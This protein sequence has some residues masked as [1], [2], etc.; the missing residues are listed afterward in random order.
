MAYDWICPKFP[1][2]LRDHPRFT[3][4]VRII[5]HLEPERPRVCIAT[6]VLTDLMRPIEFPKEF[7]FPSGEAEWLLTQM[8]DD[9]ERAFT[10][11]CDHQ[12][13]HF[14]INL[15]TSDIP[16]VGQYLF[17]LCEATRLLGE[18]RG[19]QVLKD[20]EEEC[21]QAIEMVKNNDK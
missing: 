21:Q 9:I 20:L 16:D 14:F 7:S 17:C 19:Q 15:K 10:G 6:A 4:G 18:E 2:R 11:K 12:F 5:S 8:L 1:S 13:P 3:D